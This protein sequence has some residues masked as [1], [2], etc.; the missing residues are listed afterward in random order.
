MK[1]ATHREI[2]K[3]V[4]Q[5]AQQYDLNVY[6]PSKGSPEIVVM[7]WRDV[8]GKE[9]GLTIAEGRTWAEVSKQLAAWRNREVYGENPVPPSS[10]IQVRELYGKEYDEAMRL[11][12]DFTGHE[13][14][15]W[16]KARV[17]LPKAAMVIGRCDGV[18]YTTVRDGKTEKYIHRFKANSAPILC[19]SPDGCQLFLFGGSFRFTDRGIVDK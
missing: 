19:A 9:I 15:P 18:L 3:R 4:M 14:E 13:G 2:K 6:P 16:A 11:F 7:Q 12:A 1:M 10:R 8:N 17:K 5:F